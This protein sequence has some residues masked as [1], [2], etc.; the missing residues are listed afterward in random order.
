M[1]VCAQGKHHSKPIVIT[2]TKGVLSVDEAL[3]S[4]HQA[5]DEVEDVGN[6]IQQTENTI[7]G[8]FNN[9]KSKF[10]QALA[11]LSSY[12]PINVDYTLNVSQKCDP[13]KYNKE[14]YHTIALI[15]SA[16]LI[17]LGVVFAFIGESWIDCLRTACVFILYTVIIFAI[18]FSQ[19][20]CM[21]S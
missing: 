15:L 13:V 1:A 2:P 4:V 18:L 14:Y 6:A 10:E 16:A 19:W 20:K 7:V 8:F 3:D 11:N 5:V 17:L 12:L 21:L 9:T